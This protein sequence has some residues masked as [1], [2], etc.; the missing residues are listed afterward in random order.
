MN[1][2]NYITINNKVVLVSDWSLTILQQCELCKISI[3]RF[4]YHN[5]LSIA[6]N[7]RMCMVE[8]KN[9]PK[10]VIACSTSL[11]KGMI[12]YTNSELVKIAR[13]NVL[14][15]LLINHPLD[16]P[17]CDQ[18]G[19]CD[20]QD[21]SMIYGSDRSRF[22]ENKRSVEDKDFGAVIKTIMTRCI[23]CTRCIRFAEE[24]TGVPIL[25]TMGRGRD[26]EISTYVSSLINMELSGNL[27]DICPVGALTSKPYAFKARPWELNSIDSIDVLDSLGSW[28][29]IDVKGNEV[30]RILP[31]KN[32]SINQEWISNRVRFFFE[33]AQINRLCFPMVQLSLFTSDYHYVPYSW[34]NAL[35][36]MTNQLI[37]SKFIQFAISD[38]VS[39]EDLLGIDYLIKYM[40]VLGNISTTTDI[41]S[42]WLI[43][44]SLE[45]LASSKFLFFL[46]TDL[47]LQCSVSNARFH[48]YN[49]MN[50][51][52]QTIY[53]IGKKALHYNNKHLGISN[54]AMLNIIEG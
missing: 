18:G 8:I 1:N 30:M 10:P 7:C 52:T 47:N 42:S 3:P 26:T 23:H 20:L 2:N 9:A 24:I 43:N 45:N 40:G 50:R 17:I 19:E 53:F 4:C 41:R 38:I 39:L 29:R 15:F 37:K 27:V 44:S 51:D 12:I 33:G 35:K 14:E 48:Q 32:D 6:G 22:Y 36:L 28:I 11:S 21:Q 16:C 25:G 46:H 13:E 49:Y 31:R 34:E 5:L 54:I